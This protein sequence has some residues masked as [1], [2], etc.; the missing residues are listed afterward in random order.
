MLGL[1]RAHMVITTRLR[2]GTSATAEHIVADVGPATGDEDISA[3]P[4]RATIQI[5][6]K[7]AYF[8][9][10]QGGLTSLLGLSAAAAKKTG[11][12][13]VKIKSGTPEYQDLTAQNTMSSLPASILPAASDTVRTSTGTQAGAKVYILTGKTTASDP[14]TTISARLTLTDARSVLPVTETLTTHGETKVVTLSGWGPKFTV[15]PPG[16]AIPYSSLRAASG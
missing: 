11:S 12:H 16:A 15:D 13:W 6:G 14:D 1:G 8:T 2:G 4:A 3:G 7:A 10:N 5:T 9:G